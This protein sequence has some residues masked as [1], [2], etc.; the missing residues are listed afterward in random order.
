MK[1]CQILQKLVDLHKQVVFNLKSLPPDPV[2][3]VRDDDPSSPFIV[4]EKTD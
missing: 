3:V 4:E 2:N 1:S